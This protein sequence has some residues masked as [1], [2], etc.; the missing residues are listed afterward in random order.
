MRIRIEIEMDHICLPYDYQRG[1]QAFLYSCLK[2]DYAR[3][4]HDGEQGEIKL[5]AFSNLYGKHEADQHGITFTD[6]AVLYVASPDHFFLEQVFQKIVKTEHI[7][8][9]GNFLPGPCMKRRLS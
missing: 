6:T 8:L 1:I 4:I 2:G 3:N 9:Y 5:F 7:E